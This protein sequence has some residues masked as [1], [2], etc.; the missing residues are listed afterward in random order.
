MRGQE[1]PAGVAEGLAI[2]RE[3]CDAV[4]EHFRGI[5]LVTPLLRYELSVEL[6]KHVRRQEK[7]PAKGSG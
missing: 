3:L 7:G 6:T 5:Y 2:A 4:L 1:G